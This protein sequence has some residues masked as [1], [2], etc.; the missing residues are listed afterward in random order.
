MT[1]ISAVTKMSRATSRSQSST[2]TV[3]RVIR[4]ETNRS[5]TALIEST[6]NTTP[7]AMIAG[8]LALRPWIVSMIVRQDD[9]AG[10]S[11][12]RKSRVP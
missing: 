10:F 8:P 2:P 9:G 6:V 12:S 5:P 1:R 7:V 11:L 3:A 4:F